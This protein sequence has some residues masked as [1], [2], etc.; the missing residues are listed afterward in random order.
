[1]TLEQLRIFVAV[2]ESEHMTRAAEAL[3]LTQPAVSAAIAALEARHHTPL[4]DRVGRRIELTQVGRMFLIEARAVLKR[5]AEAELA[6]SETAGLAR[7]TLSIHA[8]QTIANYWLPA[9]LWRFRRRY[10]AIALDVAIGNTAQVAA[11]VRDGGADLGLI[12]GRIDDRDLELAR[13]EGDALVLVV[14]PDHPWAGRRKLDPSRLVERPWVLRELGSGTRSEFEEALR[15][16]GV[17]PARL[18]VVLAL[19]SNEAVRAAV[20]AGAGATAIS[21]LVVEASLRSG[22]LKRVALDLPARPFHLLRHR[23]RFR[24]RAAEAFAA[25]VGEGA[26]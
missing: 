14:A 15:G 2:A 22:A 21:H 17:D 11:S 10:P 13:I 3:R 9:I 19:P 8:S 18:D 4:F 26:G 1:V 7:G 12:E 6:L 16:F 24:S 25:L 23:A 5:A 20:E